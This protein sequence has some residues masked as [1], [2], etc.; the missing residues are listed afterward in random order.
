L[1]QS[2]AS[3]FVGV[4]SEKTSTFDPK[5]DSGAIDQS[6]LVAGSVEAAWQMSALVWPLAFLSTAFVPA[7]SM[8]AGLEAFAANQP[9]SEAIDATRAL[10]LGEPVG[11]HAWIT[12][13]WCLGITVAAAAA[14]RILFRRRF[15]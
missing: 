1:S 13:A 3:I 5:V 14:A 6:G 11:D 10:L 4:T 7:E 2:D 9:I 15:S 8:P 12:V